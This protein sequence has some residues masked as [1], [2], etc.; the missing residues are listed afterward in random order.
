MREGERIPRISLAKST[1]L[2]VCETQSVYLKQV[3]FTRVLF[4][5]KQKS[6]PDCDPG[7]TKTALIQL[8][9]QVGFH[10]PDTSPSL[11]K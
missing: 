6:D 7:I 2:N 4:S 11:F 10:F 5:E 3:R 9:A 8:M 1:K